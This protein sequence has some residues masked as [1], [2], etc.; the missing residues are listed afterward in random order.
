MEDTGKKTCGR[1][2]MKETANKKKEREKREEK[3][4]RREI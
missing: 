4:E 2:Y 3:E 1:D